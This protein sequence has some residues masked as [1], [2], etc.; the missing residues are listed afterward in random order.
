M[1]T[2]ALPKLGPSAADIDHRSADWS[3]RAHSWVEETL[4]ALHGHDLMLHVERGHRI[5]LRCATCGH[6]TPGWDTK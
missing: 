3:G 1:F 2:E 4:C 6:E 5:C